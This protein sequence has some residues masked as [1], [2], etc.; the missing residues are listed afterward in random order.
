MSAIKDKLKD[1]LIGDV[2]RVVEASPDDGII[3]GSLDKT[4][5]DL[6]NY[7]I[8]IEGEKYILTKSFEADPFIRSINKLFDT[9]KFTKFYKRFI[10][11]YIFCLAGVLANQSVGGKIK[12][13]ALEENEIN[14]YV[15]DYYFRATGRDPRIVWKKRSMFV[16]FLQI[17]VNIFIQAA[18]S[19][20]SGFK[21]SKGIKQ[22]KL[23]REGLWGLYDTGGAY[24]HDDFLVDGEKIRNDDLLLF[25]WGIS[26]NDF[27]RRKAYDDA[28]KSPYSHFDIKKL[29][30]GL[31]S[32][33]LRIMP[34]YVFFSTAYL[35]SY[36][37]SNN[38][39]FYR[40]AFLSF[41]ISAI[42]YEKVFSHYRFTSTLGHMFFSTSHIAESIICENYNSRYY[43]MHWSDVSYKDHRP[44]LSHMGCDKFLGWGKI[45]L[46][47]LNVETLSSG[48]VFKRFIKN[49]A[50]DK[51][52]I[53]T[54]MGVSAGKK[55]ISFFDESFSALCRMT[56]RHYV[57]FWELAY[58]CALDNPGCEIIIKTK[59][60]QMPNSLEP[61]LY[62]IFAELSEKMKKLSNVH[63]IDEKRFSFI[64]AIGVADIVITEGMT[65]SATIAI[66]CGITG[67]YFDEA[68]YDHPLKERFKGRIV[69]DDP[70]KLRNMISSI[71]AGKEDP[72]KEI[73]E[74]LLRE[75][76]EYSD[77]RGIDIFREVIS[78]GL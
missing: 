8:W 68:G 75:Y 66:I 71:I 28:R 77:D 54:Q 19:L 11:Q 44:F 52:T 21:L 22:F 16:G 76:D 18:L 26:K 34:K 43:L 14:C 6:L 2:L 55:I 7:D 69:F 37:G 9:G 5:L 41:S 3:P 25:S 20:K 40:S 12:E 72:L 15:A 67:L 48:Y 78:K 70:L 51:S 49:V 13:I 53:L 4:L 29:S 27:Y 17:F 38:F 47:G 24:F 61:E 56:S 63:I 64:E 30:I 60:P 1:Y 46:D 62:S 36:L 59:N 31:K 58:H 57:N 65:S 32:F 45:H 42:P 73:P 39:S 35:L 33:I 23:L 50:R 10:L 74:S